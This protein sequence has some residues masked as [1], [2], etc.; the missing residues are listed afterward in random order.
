MDE[1]EKNWGWEVWVVSSRVTAS[2]EREIKK[3]QR[4]ESLVN[5]FWCPLLFNP[6][7]YIQHLSATPH[8][9]DST[10]SLTN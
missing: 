9:T 6:V 4:G 7:A 8:L 1:S 10:A 3:A 5:S 2:R